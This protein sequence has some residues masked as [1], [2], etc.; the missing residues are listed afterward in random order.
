MNG[1]PHR[2]ITESLK[3]APECIGGHTT[4]N[5]LVKSLQLK[6]N[7]KV[8]KKKAIERVRCVNYTFRILFLELNSDLLLIKDIRL[9]SA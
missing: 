7:K 3:R 1:E 2:R 6:T 8:A 9:K 5:S 4:I